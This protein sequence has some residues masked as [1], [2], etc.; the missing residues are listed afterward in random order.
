MVGAC[1]YEMNTGFLLIKKGKKHFP[2]L[3]SPG[4]IIPDNFKISTCT[5]PKRPNAGHPSQ[6]GK[7][8]FLPIKRQKALSRHLEISTNC[9]TCSREFGELSVKNF[10]KKHVD[11]WFRT[12]MS[13]HSCKR[14][15]FPQMDAAIMGGK[16][17][18][19]PTLLRVL[20]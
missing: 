18:Q 15:S 1:L 8:R 16:Y 19:K 4:S 9:R 17:S 3:P 2:R 5:K 14:F 12:E 11:R 6:H 13:I 20:E 7:Q 10:T